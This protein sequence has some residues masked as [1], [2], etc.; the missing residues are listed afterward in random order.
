[1]ATIGILVIMSNFRRLGF[2]KRIVLGREERRSMGE[3]MQ[4]GFRMCYS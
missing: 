1:M 4:K 3:M 2:Y